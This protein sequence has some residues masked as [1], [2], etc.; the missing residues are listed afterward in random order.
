MPGNST[1]TSAAYLIGAYAAA[2][3]QLGWDPEAEAA[4]LDGVL[5]LDGVSGLEVPFTGALHKYDE[6]WFL[7]RLPATADVV[8][9]L[10]PGTMARLKTMPSFGIASTDD[11]GRRA[12]LEF[13]ADALLAVGRLNQAA[14][15]ESVTAVQIHTAPVHQSGSSSPGALAA[16]LAE[17]ASWEWGGAQLVIEHCDAAVPGQVPA[18]GFLGLE[19][20]AETVSGINADGGTQIAMAVNWGRTVIEQRRPEA[21]EEQISFLRHAGLLGGL[22]FSGCSDVDTRYGTAWADVHVPPAPL[23]HGLTDDGFLESASLLTPGRIRASL[24]A[25]GTET[26]FRAVKFAA[27][28]AAGVAAR[29]AAISA[30]LSA[31]TGAAR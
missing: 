17:L 11:A 24:A 29:I 28:P 22:T 23:G 4:F 27:P 18:K 5:A 10:L 6:G 26:G 21:A 12:A 16:S 30:A 2:P 3:S 15:R 20:E 14:G 31:V 13:V 25:A 9:T 1:N 7:N 8:L 19:A